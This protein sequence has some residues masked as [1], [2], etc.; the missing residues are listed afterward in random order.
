MDSVEEA[1]SRQGRYRTVK[2]NLEVKVGE[3]WARI[4]SQLERIRIVEIGTP[5]GQVIQRTEISA[6][7]KAIL[8]CLEVS[9]PKRIHEISLRTRP[10][11]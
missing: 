5:D 11:A 6:A 4:R 10:N 7:Q 9:E 2:E 3:S 8:T 1:L